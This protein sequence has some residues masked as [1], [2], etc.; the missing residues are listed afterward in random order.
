[1]M[2]PHG[3]TA[4]I[5]IV[6]VTG[7][8]G[9]T[10]TTRLIAHMVKMMGKKVGYTTS[11]GI[12][13]QNH[14]LDKGDCTGPVS[15]E[16]VLKDPTID[17]AV[18]ETARGGLLRA[19]LG[20]HHCDIAIVTNVA[21]DHLGLRG[22]NTVEQMARL[23]GVVPETVL[24]DGY[25]ILNADDDLV[26]DMRENLKCNI[27]LFS[28]DENNER[29]QRHM[30]NNGLSA[31]YENGFITICKGTWK[32]R[33]CKTVN[34]PLTFGGKAR[35]MIQ[36]VLPA[37]LTGYIQGFDLRDI[38]M[39]LESFIPSPSQTPGRLNLFKFKG[40]D[41][42]L[43]YAHNAA[44]MHALREFIQNLS[45]TPK[46][47][48]IAGVGDRREEDIEEIGEIAAMMF[49]EVIIRQDK[50][51]RGRTE[52]ELIDLLMNGIKRHDPNKKVL[53]FK[54][55][56]EAITF[57]IENAKPGSLITMCSDVVPD[58]LKL[59]MDFKEKEAKL[60]YGKG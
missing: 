41:V 1:M 23:K 3:S 37:V 54:S 24:P 42:L 39:T 50:N 2:Y 9:K 18:L 45:G 35:F 28:M 14:M 20:F 49:D 31:I 11:D 19:G 27:A 40:F 59:V 38:K 44:G 4:R 22:I 51:L 21:P 52:Q 8:N 58:A 47:G 32:M 29:I 36:N 10:T 56:A 25:A 12:Y 6:A 16:F 7:T 60:L 26:Y 17:F 55:E 43:D 30:A 13:I 5:P 15:A 46:V 53:L 57:A 34:V 48:I 33:V